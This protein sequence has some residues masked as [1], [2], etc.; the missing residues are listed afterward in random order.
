MDSKDLD[1]MRLALVNFNT[2]QVLYTDVRNF[3]EN[4]AKLKD[5]NCIDEF[6]LE[7]VLKLNSGN[8][9]T[10]FSCSGHALGPI[11]VPSHTTSKWDFICYGDNDFNKAYLMLD[12][13]TI[14]LLA[15]TIK[16][17]KHW[18]LIGN[19]L[20][21]KECEYKEL[22]CYHC[23]SIN[24]DFKTWSEAI[25]ELYDIVKS[26]KSDFTYIQLTDLKD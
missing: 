22:E 2:K 7:P 5:F 18:E 26:I 13:F 11:Y 24:I 25:S 3:K 12:D 1:F 20:K 15:E 23:T 9:H 19:L 14:T 16:Q 6:I 21:I 4:E 10:K 8:F 17:S